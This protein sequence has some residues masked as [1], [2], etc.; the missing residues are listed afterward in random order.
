[1]QD[2]ITDSH[3]SFEQAMKTATELYAEEFET[4]TA[5]EQQPWFSFFFDGTGNNLKRDISLNKLSNVARLYSGHRED[6]PLIVPLYYPGVGTPLDASEPSWVDSIRDSE[7]LGGGAGLGGDA[8]LQLA[9]TEFLSALSKTHRVSR[10]DIAVFGFSRGATLARSFVNRVLRKCEYRSGIPHWPC[11]TARDGKAAPIYFRFL[12]IFDTVESVG[13][14]AHDLT[15]MQMHVP[16]EVEKCLHLVSGHEIRSAFPLTPLG[17]TS[18]TH[19]EFVYPGVHSDVGGG[20]KPREQARSDMLARMPLNRMR[21]E[22][23]IAGVPFTPPALL[24]G[25]TKALFE[26]DEAVK[27]AFDACMAVTDLTGSL[28]QQIAAHMHLYYGWLK[29]RYQ[30]NP[31]D[32]YRNVCGANR[33]SQ[34]DLQ[35]IEASRTDIAAQADSLNWRS[36]MMALSKSNPNEYRDRLKTAGVPP[37][38]SSDEQDYYDAWVNPPTLSD[39]LIHF[40][41]SYVHDSR[42][43]FKSLIGKGL[44][45]MPRGIVKPSDEQQIIVKPSIDSVAIDM[46][47]ADAGDNVRGAYAKNQSL[48]VR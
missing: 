11:S 39:G 31:C 10:I 14:P 45:L 35:R 42:A 8:R 37:P 26:Y 28:Q 41:D 24:D 19:R 12:G 36:Y 47:G 32:V 17:K 4:C 3:E 25:T 6:L 29:A 46:S 5:C 27:A 44:Y 40:F 13:L 15:D 20:Y 22:G 33:A 38:L 30:L 34:I 21:L 9:E 48:T 23:A 43:G 18:D 1:M 7:L 2:W 16:D